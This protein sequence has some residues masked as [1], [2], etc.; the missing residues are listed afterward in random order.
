MLLARSL[1]V[2]CAMIAGARLLA[3]TAQTA[4]SA[5]LRGQNA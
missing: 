1:L 5:D 2:L 4:T 3:Q